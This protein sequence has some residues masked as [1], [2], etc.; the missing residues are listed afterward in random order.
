MVNTADV[1]DTLW[2]VMEYS[3]IVMVGSEVSYGM[4]MEG[5]WLVF[6][7]CIIIVIGGV[8]YMLGCSIIHNVICRNG[9]HPRKRQ[10][11]QVCKS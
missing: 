2:N 4:V 3:I 10:L 5:L 9:L 11:F 8:G 1:M 6:H 7:N